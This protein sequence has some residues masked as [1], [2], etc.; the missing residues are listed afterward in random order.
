MDPLSLAASIVGLISLAGVTLRVTKDYI[1]EAKH[2]QET[3]CQ[4]LQEL[5]ILHFNLARLDEFLRSEHKVIGKFDDTSILV[6]STHACRTKL[7]TLHDKLVEGIH[8]RR[9]L[10]RALIS[11]LQVKEHRELIIELRTFAQWVQFSLTINGCKLLA[12]T[13][14][15][16]LDV[17][18]TQLE[19]FQLLQQ[20]DD[21]TKM[22]ER[23]QWEHSQALDESRAKKERD[24]V[25]DWIS[26]FKHQTKHHDVCK[27]RIRDTGD[28]LPDD[29]DF[30]R[31][32]RPDNSS[33]NLLWCYGIQG[34]GKTILTYGSPAT[35]RNSDAY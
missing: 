6:S 1:H 34:S 8:T 30:K 35:L 9:S 17:L 23:L 20:V 13:L 18:K 27:P 16:I 12:K 3:A 15:D 14:A 19:S 22:M 25:L 28:W 33:R 24:E 11:P 32:S 29:C 10:L 4:F 7:S 31:W 21:R 2:E 5:D 26:V